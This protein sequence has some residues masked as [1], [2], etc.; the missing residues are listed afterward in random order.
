MLPW[1]EGSRRVRHKEQT[2][3][4]RS[5]VKFSVSPKFS[6]ML[7]H[8]R[9]KE[10]SWINKFRIPS[11]YRVLWWPVASF[12]SEWFSLW[13]PLNHGHENAWPSIHC[14]PGTV[15]QTLQTSPY[16]VLILILIFQLRKLRHIWVK[17]YVTDLTQGN[18]I[19][20][21]KSR[22]SK[23]SS[24]AHTHNYSGR[25]HWNLRETQNGLTESE[26]LKGSLKHVFF[27]FQTQRSRWESLADTLA[28]VRLKIFWPPA[29]VSFW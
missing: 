7:L 8:L 1:K 5:D 9:N 12:R 19:S 18:T 16:L 3:R 27:F 10:F 26:S 25:F 29:P 2:L 6:Q 28:E 23:T 22:H 13:S 15:P 14:L 4:E 24:L 21:E 20:K 17:S 11:I